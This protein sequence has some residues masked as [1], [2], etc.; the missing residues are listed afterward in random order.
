LSILPKFMNKKLH[1]LTDKELILFNKIL[2]RDKKQIEVYKSR[3]GIIYFK[4]IR[5]IRVA[6][7]CTASSIYHRGTLT[8][9]RKVRE[10]IEINLFTGEKSKIIS[11][12]Y[13]T[14]KNSE[15]KRL[16]KS[17]DKSLENYYIKAYLAI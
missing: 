10:H 15:S 1:E 12:E 8:T 5:N 14:I 9:T 11:N 4:H 6:N 2:E 3:K 16:A 13:V 17:I 7:N